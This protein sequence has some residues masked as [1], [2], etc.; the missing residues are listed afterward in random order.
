MRSSPLFALASIAACLSGAIAPRAHAQQFPQKFENLKVFPK[1][2]PRDTLLGI[3][4][5]FTVAL[6]VRCTYCHVS[7]PGA[8]GREQLFFARDDKKTKNKARFMLRMVDSL[9]HAVLPNLPDRRNPPVQVRCITCHRGLPVPATLTTLL[10]AAVDSFGVDSAAARYQR[11][12]DDMESG[13]YDLSEGSVSDVARVLAER[14]RVQD[15]LALLQVNQRFHPNSAEIDFEMGDLYRRL[16]DRDRAITSYRT[17]LVKRPND[18][19][20]LQR[21]RELGAEPSKQ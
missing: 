9:D 11:L 15:A 12:R 3:M 20:V 10:T 7:E 8:N 18:P 19:R 2:I 16:G 6:G 5:G 14:G 1:D 21:L 4:R 17:A 13:R